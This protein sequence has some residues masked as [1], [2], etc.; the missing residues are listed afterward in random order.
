[1]RAAAEELCSPDLPLILDRTALR[2]QGLLDVASSRLSATTRRRPDVL[3]LTR[4]ALAV[5][6]QP[7]TRTLVDFALCAR[8]RELYGIGQTPEDL[9]QLRQSFQELEES[10]EGRQRRRI[11]KDWSPHAHFL[12]DVVTMSGHVW[13][14]PD[15]ESFDAYCGGFSTSPFG[16]ASAQRHF[17]PGS[18]PELFGQPPAFSSVLRR[19]YGIPLGVPGLDEALGALQVPVPGP[20]GAP[21]SITLVCGPS[22]SGRTTLLLSIASALSELGSAV[23]LLA[24][25]ESRATLDSKLHGLATVT[26]SSLWSRWLPNLR[27]GRGRLEIVAVDSPAALRA[28]LRPVA[29]ATARESSATATG[30]MLQHALFL[31]G[32]SA[33]PPPR[34]RGTN[35]PAPGSPAL[36]EALVRLRDSG[37]C[38]FL[39]CTDAERETFGLDRLADNVFRLG[40]HSDPTGRHTSRVLSVD[41][42]RLQSSQRDRHVVNIGETGGCWVSPSLHTVNRGLASLRAVEPSSS[43]AFQ[44]PHRAAVPPHRRA[45]APVLREGSHVLIHGQGSSG[46]A[47]LALACALA[48]STTVAERPPEPRRTRRRSGARPLASRT[49]VVSFLYTEPYYRKLA[50]R[51]LHGEASVPDTLAVW[52]LYPGYIDAETFISNLQKHLATAELLGRPFGAV[53]LDGI[54]NLLLEFP[55]LR[56]DD[57]LWPTLFRLLRSHG[58]RAIS[59][60]SSFDM[61]GA[62]AS[63]RPFDL[64][65]AASSHDAFFPVLASACDYVLEMR[66]DEPSNGKSRSLVSVESSSSDGLRVGDRYLWEADALTLVQGRDSRRVARAGSPAVR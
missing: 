17:G 30:S 6:E 14:A 19:A 32:I 3:A 45:A 37:A 18:W 50:T 53:V 46:K 9:E 8:L 36:P 57:L 5:P 34:A 22:G 39:S 59:T 47:G 35:R 64:E 41:K 2:W 28:A 33:A 43:H 55:M 16:V 48:A 61:P 63:A 15:A 7:Y 1:M 23:R 38:V 49:L 27:A 11:K 4:D 62:S 24:P 54:H 65:R 20:G 60:F 42:T 40:F 29:G 56:A 13:R 58:I 44:V 51:L 10:F 31:D 66:R 21:G 26:P 12:V 52:T 25:A